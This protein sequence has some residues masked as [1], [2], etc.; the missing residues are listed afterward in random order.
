M[1]NDPKKFSNFVQATTTRVPHSERSYRKGLGRVYGFRTTTH[2]GYSKEEINS[3]L[4]DGTPEEVQALTAYFSKVS[5]IY[6]STIEYLSSLLSYNYLLTPHYD[7]SSPPKKLKK[8]YRSCAAYIKNSYLKKAFPAINQSIFRSGVYYGLVRENENGEGVTFYKLPSQYCRSRYFDQYGNAILELNCTYFNQ[9]AGTDKDLLHS[10]L[11]LFPRKVKSKVLSRSNLSADYWI[12][13]LPTEGGMCFYF[14]DDFTSPL[15]SSTLAVLAAQD[16]RE[17]EAKRDQ[18]EMQKILI[19]KLPIDKTDGTLI[20]SLEEATELHAGVSAM[21]EDNDTIDV[22]TTYADVKLEEVQEPDAAASSSASRQEKYKSNI[23]DDIGISGELFNAGGAN[24]MKYSIK[25]DISLL[26]KW[27]RQYEVWLNTW[28]YHKAAMLTKSGNPTIYFS[29]QFLPTTEIFRDDDISTYLKTAQYGY[30]K[31]AVAA[32]MDIEPL[33]V[34][35]LL[36]FENSVLKLHDNMIPLMSSYT[37][38]GD[39]KNSS[40]S[41]KNSSGQTSQKDLTNEGGRPE[42]SDEERAE[43][44]LKNRDGMT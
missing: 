24:T 25:K 28:L 3:I 39:E 32:A 36:D 44:T 2:D 42:K 16:A 17:R 10:L 18:N 7:T 26:M 34:L 38:S 40:G 21:L 37:T 31:M 11:K 33:D 9:V 1:S 14:K 13:I 6:A 4:E 5:G 22:M 19:Q 30:P 43:R 8:A 29:I 23:Y 15:T 41:G 35:Q 12:E 20:F 27:S